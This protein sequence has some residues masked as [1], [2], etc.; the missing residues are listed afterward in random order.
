M[1]E[2]TFEDEGMSGYFLPEDSQLLLKQLSG[3][4]RFLARLAQPRV[5][6]EAGEWTPA[7]G[8]ADLM[9]CLDQ[10]AG[11]LDL[12]LGA[13]SWPARREQASGADAL[14]QTA[15]SE[16][17][18]AQSSHFAHSCEDGFAFGATVDQIDRLNALISS[19]R[20]YGDVISTGEYRV[21]AAGTLP[22]L[23]SAIF[24]DACELRALVSK[25]ESQSFGWG[26]P[27]HVCVGESRL[28]YLVLSAFPSDSRPQKTIGAPSR[29][30]S[31]RPF[32]LAA[33]DATKRLTDM[34]MRGE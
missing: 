33:K 21:L 2:H 27:E 23:G 17:G 31:W 14:E 16:G 34:S 22:A 32:R 28:S 9:F 1:A 20:A 24:D 3:Y 11:Q 26:R 4:I 18:P 7:V 10:L 25:L 19:I 15:L 6:D 8:T 30:E 29:L 13:L 12:V 5:P